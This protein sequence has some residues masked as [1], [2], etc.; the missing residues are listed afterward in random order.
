[1]LLLVPAFDLTVSRVVAADPATVWAVLSD[2]TRMGELSPETTTTSYLDGATAPAPG[3]RF[4]GRNKVR[5]LSWTTVCTVHEVEAER[6]LRF[7]SSPPSRS[8]WT[9]RLEL[10]PEGTLVTE[11]MTKQNEQ[12]APVRL[13]QSLVGVRDR[14]ASLR[15]GM[16]ATLERLEAAAVQE[17]ANRGGE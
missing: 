12:P 4:R 8:T 13:L 16:E 6:L 2:L 14:H 5:L 3:V 11:T 1:M 10:V 9:Y 17:L 7:E 15:Q